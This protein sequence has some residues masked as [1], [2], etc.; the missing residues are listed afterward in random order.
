MKNAPKK[1]RPDESAYVVIQR[2]LINRLDNALERMLANSGW[3]DG[4]MGWITA[5][6]VEL[7]KRD[8]LI[9]PPPELT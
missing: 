9:A 3:F 2:D 7:I 1:I 4:D 5:C 6:A 8:L